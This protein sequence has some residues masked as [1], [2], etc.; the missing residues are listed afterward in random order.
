M[1][2][3]DKMSADAI[4]ILSADAIQKAKSGHP[5]LP[6]GCADAAYALWAKVLK[7]NPAN[8]DWFN[9]DRFILS[10]DMAPASVLTASPFCYGLKKEDLT[11]SSAGLSDSRTSGV[12]SHCR[13]RSNN[14]TARSRNGNGSRNGDGRRTSGSE[15]Q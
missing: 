8:P 15:V 13:S 5:G 9:R 14:R 6:L 10:E 11:V 3:I 12:S 1:N 7:H 2:N 4:R